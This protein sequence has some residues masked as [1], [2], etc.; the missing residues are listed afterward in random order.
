MKESGN[1]IRSAV[2]VK[3]I[4]LNISTIFNAL[5]GKLF[6]SYWNK[7]EGEFKDYKIHGQGRKREK[8]SMSLLNTF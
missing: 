1:I 8:L 5:K 2:K 3:I 7:Y 6:W 4:N